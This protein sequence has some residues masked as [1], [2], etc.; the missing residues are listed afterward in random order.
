MQFKDSLWDTSLDFADI[1]PLLPLRVVLPH[2]GL[3]LWVCGQPC[4]FLGAVYGLS[5]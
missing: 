3:R 4:L 5:W 1:H 2:T